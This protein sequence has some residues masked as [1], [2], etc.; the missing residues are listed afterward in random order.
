VGLR[1]PF[2]H[3]VIDTRSASCGPVV[4]SAITG[5]G[6]VELALR[7]DDRSVR[8]TNAYDLALRSVI[9]ATHSGT[10]RAS[11]D[12]RRF[13]T[14]SKIAIRYPCGSAADPLGLLP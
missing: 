1:C 3:A 4:I 9:S 6:R 2:G 11:T 7:R 14:G 12:R 5:M 10:V 8:S 13:V